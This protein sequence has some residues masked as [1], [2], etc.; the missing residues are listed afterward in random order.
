[1]AE[2]PSPAGVAVAFT[3]AW[4]GH[5]FAAAAAFLSDDVVYDGPVNHIAVLARTWKRWRAS[6]SQ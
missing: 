2:H 5:D 4:T 6:R 1:M 3:Q